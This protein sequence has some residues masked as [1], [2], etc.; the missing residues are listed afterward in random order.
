MR[1]CRAIEVHTEAYKTKQVYKRSYR[2]KEDSTAPLGP[3]GTK[4]DHTGPFGTIQYR[5]GTYRIVKDP[6]RP[7]GAV[8]DHMGP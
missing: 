3:Y 5:M 6:K 1:P 4:R 8:K 7:Y 2:T